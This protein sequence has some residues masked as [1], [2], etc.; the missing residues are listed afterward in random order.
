MEREF[1]AWDKSNGKYWNGWSPGAYMLSLEGKLLETV[2]GDGGEI[3][4]IIE[5]E[6][7]GRFEFEPYI[8]R[9]EKNG[10]KLF[11]GDI[12]LL[13]ENDRRS[14]CE[15]RIEWSDDKLGWIGVTD[16]GPVE[17]PFCSFME[18]VG[19]IHKGE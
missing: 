1:R 9:R 6:S 14:K 4:T 5:S 8:G 11:A 2:S 12:V 18:L 15:A 16:N 3:E 13:D 7:E 19:N 10:H 17:L